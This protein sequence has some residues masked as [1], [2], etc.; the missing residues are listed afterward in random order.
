[1]QDL[2]TLPGQGAGAQSQALGINDR[3]QVVG[4][5]CTARFASCQAFLWQNGVMTNLNALVAAGYHDQLVQGSDINDEG[6]ITGEAV[7]ASGAVRSFVAAPGYSRINR[8]AA[9]FGGSSQGVAF[10]AKLRTKLLQR[11]G[12][13]PSHFD[14]HR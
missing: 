10:P 11:M 4:L 5:S 2:G 12:L 9:G 3:G 7:D 14:E 1:M 13:K 6:V 8:M